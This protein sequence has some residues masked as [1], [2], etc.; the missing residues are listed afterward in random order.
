VKG[1]PDDS[2]GR[3]RFV[4]VALGGGALLSELPQLGNELRSPQYTRL[5]AAAI[6]AILVLLVYTYLRGRARWWNVPVLPVLVAVGGAGLHD[7]LLGTALALS[8]LVVFS[9]YGSTRMWLAR[10]V[11]TL[12]GL[13]AAVAISPRAAD[14]PMAWNSPTVIG[15]LPQ[16]LLMALLIRGIYVAMRRMERSARRDAV[17]AR[18]G[19]AMIGKTDL[20][21][22]R[23]I[24]RQAAAELAELCPGV[25]MLVVRRRADGLRIVTL[26]GAPDELRDRAVP[27]ELIADPARLAELLPG[28]RWWKI[29]PLGADPATA[30]VLIAL[31]GRRPVPTE[32]LDGFRTCSNQVILAEQTCR[33][34]AELEHLAHH[35]HLTRLPTRTKFFRTLEGA[36]VS[37]EAGAVAL[38]NVDLDDF[39]QVNDRYG[40]PSGDELLAEVAARLAEVA[41]GRGLAA[42]FGGDEFAILLTGLSGTA[43]AREIADRLGARLAEPVAL[44]AATVTP[45]ASIGIATSEPG[46]TAAELSRRADLAMYSAKAAGK[47]RIEAFGPACARM[48]V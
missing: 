39:K 3:T 11:G 38:L 37:A 21:Q 23:A 31:G 13:I 33:A 46:I 28:H 7:P 10:A 18:T 47:R 2:L 25:A 36:L 44:S 17:L 4:A 32:V 5:A 34:H 35:D 45:G 14:R 16:L 48:P 42:R 20:A 6:M 26:A 8:N 29:D 1:I 22:V 24:G 12:L 19:Q 27:D 43:E 41:A 30:E 15:V 9:L 40:H